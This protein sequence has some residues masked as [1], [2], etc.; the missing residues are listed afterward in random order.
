MVKKLT[1]LI[2]SIIMVC[3]VVGVSA[4]A[5]EDAGK[6]AA[7][8][9]L[10]EVKFKQVSFGTNDGA[11]I[12]TDGNLYMWGR[13]PNG[14]LG[15]GTTEDKYLPT[16]I[17]SN[18]VEVSLNGHGYSSAAITSDGSLYTWGW[19]NYGQLGDGTTEDKHTPTKIM[20]NVVSVSLGDSHCLAI[21]TD[22][23]LYM[24]GN[25]IALRTTKCILTPTK[26][27]ENVT[28]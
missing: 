23:S 4:G 16:K 18:V 24:W 6:P 13:N 12:T 26:I 19:N 5:V 22:G 28:K 3:S 15:D 7:E 25:N 14:Q 8:S 9:N 20:E 2:L 21:T 11:A 1:A 17:M 27:M 10:R